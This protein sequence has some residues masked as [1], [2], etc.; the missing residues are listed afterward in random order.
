MLVDIQ[1][2]SRKW[3]CQFPSWKSNSGW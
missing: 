3:N 1:R 2:Y